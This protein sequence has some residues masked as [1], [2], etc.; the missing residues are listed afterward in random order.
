MD[1]SRQDGVKK[2]RAKAASLRSDARRA[3]SSGD[4]KTAADLRSS[5]KAW[6]QDA[7]NISCHGSWTTCKHGGGVQ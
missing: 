3:E 1:N 2:F 5:A 4:K 7:A 6:D